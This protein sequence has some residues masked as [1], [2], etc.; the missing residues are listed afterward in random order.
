MENN[1][2]FWLQVN[3]NKGSGWVKVGVWKRGINFNNNQ[4]YEEEVEFAPGAFAFSLSD[5]LQLRFRCDASGNNDM[6]YIDD[7]KISGWE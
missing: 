2:D 3:D 5:N 6:V 7:G 1:E 4:F